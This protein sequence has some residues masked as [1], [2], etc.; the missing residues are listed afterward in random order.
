MRRSSR[1][2]LKNQ[3]VSRDNEETDESLVPSRLVAEQQSLIR[4][5]Q[6]QVELLNQN[7]NRGFEIISSVSASL[8]IRSG[9]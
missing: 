4:I 9:K 6:A 1:H 3:I 5:L 8:G 7:Q 2:N